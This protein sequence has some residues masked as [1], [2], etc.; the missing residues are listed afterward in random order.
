MVKSVVKKDI[1][2]NKFFIFIYRCEAGFL[3][4]LLSVNIMAII[5]GMYISGSIGLIFNILLIMNK[6]WR[7]R[8]EF[9]NTLDNIRNVKKMKG[10]NY[11]G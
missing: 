6:F 2:E 10:G 1:R 7:L 11:K 8:V 4:W 5:L 3:G 9:L